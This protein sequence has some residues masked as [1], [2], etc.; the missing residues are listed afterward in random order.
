MRIALV[1][2]HATYDREDN[3]RRGLEALEK[4]AENDADLVCYAELAFEPFYPQIPAA[5]D[6]KELA[7]AVPGP[8]T[9]AFSQR[10]ADLGVVVVLNLYERDDDRCY[11][12]SPVIDRDGSLLGRARMVH[13]TDYP[14]FPTAASWV[15]RGWFTSR[16]TRVFMSRATTLQVTLALRSSIPQSARSES[17]SATTVTT[18]STCERSP[19]PAPRS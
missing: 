19:S 8:V 10:A 1:Q 2:Q 3:L 7:Q 11:D 5:E 15:G 9:E 13:I 18:P 6:P 12:T 17:R 14:C 4:A 16:I